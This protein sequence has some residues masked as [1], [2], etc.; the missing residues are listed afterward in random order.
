MLKVLAQLKVGNN[1]FQGDQYYIFS[2]KST[3]KI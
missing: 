1:I 3:T 2:T